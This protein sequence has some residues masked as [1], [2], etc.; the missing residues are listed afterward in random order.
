ML[1]K[2]FKMTVKQ[3]KIYPHIFSKIVYFSKNQS[4]S[5]VKGDKII[6]SVRVPY[7]NGTSKY[8]INRD[9]AAMTD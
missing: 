9:T 2:S 3:G 1:K 6:I 5:I 4:N 7:N 8:F